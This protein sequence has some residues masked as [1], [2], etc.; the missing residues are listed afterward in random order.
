M[1][2]DEQEGFAMRK[3]T[4]RLTAAALSAVMILGG[5]CPASVAAARDATELYPY[6]VFAASDD[7]GAVT[8]NAQSGAVNGTVAAGGTVNRGP[9]LAGSVIENAGEPM[10]FI[11]NKLDETYFGDYE[12]LNTYDGG[13]TL[14]EPDIQLDTPTKVRGETELTGNVR[15]DAALESMGDIRIKGEVENANNSVLCSKYGDIR[16]DGE[17]VSF[18][19]L[20]YAP[21]GTVRIS[22]ENLNLNS[23]VVIADKIVFTC[24]NLNLNGSAEV[25]AFVGG[26]SEEFF[27]PFE[28][29]GYLADTDSDGLP[30]VWEE[31]NGSSA[32][33]TDTDKDGLPDGYE[34]LSLRT[35]PAAK[36]TDENGIADTDED[37]DADGLSNGEEYGLDTGPWNEDTDGEGLSDGDE[38]NRYQTDPLKPDT[39][40]DG[41]SDADEIALGTD[42]NSADTDEDGIP[43]DEEKFEQTYVYETESEDGV[44][45]SVTLSAAA[46]G[47]LSSTTY[48]EDIGE[49]DVICGNIAGLVGT[50]FSIETSSQF[51]T[52]TLSFRIH[53]EKLRSGWDFDD[54]L[55]LWYDEENGKFEELKT[56]HDRENHIVSVQTT[57]LG[58]YMIVDSRLWYAA[59]ERELNYTSGTYEKSVCDVVLAVDCSGSMAD[60]DP[61]TVIPPSSAPYLSVHDCERYRAVSNFVLFLDGDDRAAIVTFDDTAQQM[62]GLTDDKERLY[63]AS[64]AFYSDGGT[65]FD[66]AITRSVEILNASTGGTR[67]KIIL[68]SDGEASISAQTLRKAADSHVRIYT[69]GL[70]GSADDVLRDIAQKTGGEFFKAYRAED[71]VD[72]YTDIGTEDDFDR[73]DTDGDGLYDAV[74]AAGIRVQNGDIISGC[75]PGK[76]D[77]DGDGIKDGEE[78]DPKPRAKNLYGYSAADGTIRGYYFEMKSNPRL[79]DSDGDGY[80]DIEDP[81][82]SQKPDYL[83]DKYDFLDGEI[84]SIVAVDC[85]SA[86]NCLDAELS[87]ADQNKS[88]TMSR[89]SSRITQKFKFEWC[90]DGYKIH[91]FAHDELVI[92]AFPNTDGE[93]TLSMEVDSNR[94]DQ[95]WEVLPYCNKNAEHITTLQTGIIMRLKNLFYADKDEVGKSL[96]LHY[97]SDSPCVSTDRAYGTRL[98]LNNITDWT[99]FGQLYMNQERWIID[100]KPDEIRR[101]INNYS[102]NIQNLSKC[103]NK[104]LKHESDPPDPVYVY[105]RTGC[106]NGQGFFEL[107]RFADVT[108]DKVGCE[109]LAAYNAMSRKGKKINLCR[110]ISEFEINA[111]QTTGPFHDGKFGSRPEKIP[112][113]LEAYA[114]SNGHTERMFYLNPFKSSSAQNKSI[115]MIQ[116]KL[117]QN[118]SVIVSAWNYKDNK[119]NVMLGIHTVYIEKADNGIVI[120]NYAN[121]SA[122]PSMDYTSINDMFTEEKDRLFSTLVIGIWL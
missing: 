110:L 22:A 49:K 56:T 64:T 85:A 106:L 40:S 5:V 38:R 82:S 2:V 44:I 88:L 43:D 121:R 93:G 78:I 119:P 102:Q 114:L 112:D 83:Q 107:L 72:I 7:E 104:M 17:N 81:D 28:E 108:F 1:R 55:I 109:V 41:L 77:T 16:I 99:R 42:P 10:I 67:R 47:N 97:N 15:L 70:G 30:D 13:Y 8:I 62:C 94:A 11:F 117:N 3:R 101:T 86:Q 53:P 111:I 113:C 6:A 18:T 92:T 29:W 12:H 52:A 96:Y 39:D 4:G 59:W 48:V 36:D 57:H 9:L 25:R 105:T 103:I 51:D 23:S 98:E 68:L 24:S 58:K 21:F 118:G 122:L 14:S 61:I 32:S 20:I 75:D 116:E 60:N 26:Q 37:F 100:E 69:V 89:Y 95:I 76:A 35:S 66:E 120:Y 31:A 27:A 87:S 65:D 46:T 19:G 50:P 91:S 74:E 90:G 45:G 63:R 54:L 115:E 73:T 80:E 79:K 33:D 71:L 34:V 84:Y